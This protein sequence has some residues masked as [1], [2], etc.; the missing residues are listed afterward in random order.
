MNK[1]ELQLW[2]NEISAG[3]LLN[4]FYLIDNYASEHC[5]GAARWNI[6]HREKKSSEACA[7][8]AKV[9]LE[10]TSYR[11]T[12]YETVREGEKAF[13]TAMFLY[14]Y[15]EAPPDE[16][17]FAMVCELVR[18]DIMDNYSSTSDLQRLMTM[19]VEKNE[20]HEAIKHFNSYLANTAGRT[21]IIKSL[22]QRLSPL[23]SFQASDSSIFEHCADTEIFELGIALLHNLGSV[24]E[25]PLGMENN[26]DE[27][28]L[29]SAALHLVYGACT[30]SKQTAETFFKL[31]KNPK[32]LESKIKKNPQIT[33]AA[34]YWDICRENVLK[35]KYNLRM[36]RGIEDFFK[37]FK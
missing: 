17:N 28:A 18:A 19:L 36:V 22:A 30:T 2:K 4:P 21:Q 8:L 10:G 11:V 5:S 33:E 1:N 7:E 3:V 35:G 31:L 12:E 23:F 24:M 14:L 6:E 13:L 25:K 29:V 15:T 34:R 20:K 26:G 27:I 16:Q 9:F 32:L 37:E